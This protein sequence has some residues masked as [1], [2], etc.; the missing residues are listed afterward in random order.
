MK[1]K[2]TLK[3]M[4][5]IGFGGNIKGYR[6]Y[7]PSSRKV[8][9][10]RDVVIMK[11]AMENNFVVSSG[12]VSGA[13]CL[14]ELPIETPIVSELQNTVEKKKDS[15]E[16]NLDESD[17]ACF[18]YAAAALSAQDDVPVTAKPIVKSPEP[19]RRYSCHKTQKI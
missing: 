18:V 12:Q 1:K 17:N 5:L 3:K 6:V 15:D 16:I 19:Q 14:N 9:H 4:I 11:K 13:A 2:K 10:S 8:I 7:D